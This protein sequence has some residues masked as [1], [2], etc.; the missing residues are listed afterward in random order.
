M[1]FQNT[2]ISL[3]ISEK[4]LPFVSMMYLCVNAEEMKHTAAKKDH[5]IEIPTFSTTGRKPCPMQ[6]LKHQCDRN[7]KDIAFPRTLSE[8]NSPARSPGIGPTP[9]PKAKM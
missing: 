2:L 4:L 8:F 3:S 6:K 5:T 7:A 9:T 1:L